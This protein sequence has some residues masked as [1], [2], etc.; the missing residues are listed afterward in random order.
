VVDGGSSPPLRKPRPLRPLSEFVPPSHIEKIL[1]DAELSSERDDDPDIIYRDGNEGRYVRLGDDQ[2]KMNEDHEMKAAGDKM[3]KGEK[4]GKLSDEHSDSNIL[5]EK[6]NDDIPDEFLE[7]VSRKTLI[8]S[9]V[10]KKEIKEKE[11]EV[12]E[13]KKLDENN[14]AKEMYQS[15]YSLS[16]APTAEEVVKLQRYTDKEERDKEEKKKMTTQAAAVYEEDEK[17]KIGEEG[18][19]LDIDKRRKEY[20]HEIRMREQFSKMASPD[21]I[22]L[23]EGFDTP[24]A[25]FDEY[26]RRKYRERPSS[27]IWSALPP[28]KPDPDLDGGDINKCKLRLMSDTVKIREALQRPEVDGGPDADTAVHVIIRNNNDNRR[29]LRKYYRD[30]YLQSLVTDLRRLLPADI[31]SVVANMLLP[32]C[33][34]DAVC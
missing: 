31:S 8:Q 15:K 23:K 32:I 10:N 25:D 17:E 7:K 28:L 16:G 13:Q 6:E 12:E 24:E 33:E 11:V 1:R 4:D 5:T 34:F 30:E 22:D 20:R 3:N 27:S 21:K 29:W 2:D 9:A 19:T 26:G 18:D 14:M